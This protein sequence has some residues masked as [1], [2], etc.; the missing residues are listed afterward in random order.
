MDKQ[1]QLNIIKEDF[2]KSQKVL[3]AIGDETRN[4]FF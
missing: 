4:L 2:M 3:L 1:E